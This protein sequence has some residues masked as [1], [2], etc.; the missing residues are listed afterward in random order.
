MLYIYTI[1]SSIKVIGKLKLG[2][3][4]GLVE[5]IACIGVVRNWQIDILKLT[6]KTDIIISCGSLKIIKK[7]I[8]SFEDR[9]IR[10][11]NI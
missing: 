5:W 1:H 6:F 8:V 3:G 4:Y 2:I 11:K 10:K 9:T 7:N